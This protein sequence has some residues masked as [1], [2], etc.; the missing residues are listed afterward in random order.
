M[1]KA[2]LFSSS[3]VVSISLVLSA[4]TR[5]IVGAAELASMRADAMIVNTSRAGLMPQAALKAA[6]LA[7]R[8]GHAG[9]DVFEIEPAGPELDLLGMPQVTLSPHL[10]YVNGAVLDAFSAGL[11]EVSAAWLDGHPTRVINA[12]T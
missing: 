12:V 8:P 4:R 2:E 6:L 7:G 10:G 1:S 11:A 5:G 9:L 3:R